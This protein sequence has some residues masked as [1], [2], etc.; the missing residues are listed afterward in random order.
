MVM[1][2]WTK[3]RQEV[4][5][6]TA[7]LKEDDQRVEAARTRTLEATLDQMASRQNSDIVLNHIRLNGWTEM[8]QAAWKGRP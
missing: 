6:L 5:E 4:A 7:K 3:H 8:L 2:P 1:W